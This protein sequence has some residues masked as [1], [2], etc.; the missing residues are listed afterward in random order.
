[1]MICDDLSSSGGS[2]LVRRTDRLPL[3]SAAKERSQH[4]RP[5]L[6]RPD[7]LEYE[8]RPEPFGLLVKDRIVDV[9]S[10]DGCELGV[11]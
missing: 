6:V 1:M 11:Q 4:R 3:R 7:A 2:S 5:E 10:D 8:S 9:G